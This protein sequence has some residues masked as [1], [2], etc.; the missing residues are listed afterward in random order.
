MKGPPQ[1]KSMQ[2]NLVLGCSQLLLSRETL[3]R[4]GRTLKQ[5]KNEQDNDVDATYCQIRKETLR[6]VA[7]ALLKL[8]GCCESRFGIS[9]I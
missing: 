1:C 2:V 9:E 6:S 8:P 5:E 3:E 4:R 7:T